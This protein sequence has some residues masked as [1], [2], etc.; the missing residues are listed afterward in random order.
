MTNAKSGAPVTEQCIPKSIRDKN[1]VRCSDDAKEDNRIVI[2]MQRT[3]AR[4]EKYKSEQ[5][6]D[7]QEV[8]K[9][10]IDIMKERLSA[11]FLNAG[12]KYAKVI[13]IMEK[14]REEPSTPPSKHQTWRTA[15]SSTSSAC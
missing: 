1:S 7:I 15:P 2:V 11:L 5:A 12:F 14:K 10:E 8:S 3:L 4:H 13:H 6:T 9:L